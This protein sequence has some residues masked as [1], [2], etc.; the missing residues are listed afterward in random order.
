MY[1]ERLCESFSGYK[2][3]DFQM[4]ANVSSTGLKKIH[5]VFLSRWFLCLKFNVQVERQAFEKSYKV[6]NRFG[7]LTQP[8]F[9][10]RKNVCN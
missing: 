5:V 7:F 2:L 1:F 3:T 9:T 10:F 8:I 6:T 4:A